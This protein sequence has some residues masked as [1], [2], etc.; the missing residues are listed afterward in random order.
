MIRLDRSYSGSGGIAIIVR[1]NLKYKIIEMESNIN[2]EYLV[3]E[4]SLNNQKKITIVSVYIQPK[5][6]TNYSFIERIGK[7]RPRNTIILGDFNSTH[8]SWGCKKNNPNGKKLKKTLETYNFNIIN[9]LE[10]TFKK[11]QNVIDLAAISTSLLHQTKN[12]KTHTNLGIS[13]HNLISF[14]LTI[15][16]F[17]NSYKITDWVKVNTILNSLHMNYQPVI[18]N[19]MDLENELLKLNTDILE[20]IDK[21]TIVKRLYKG[22]INLPQIIL[23]QINEKKKLQR[24][25]SK[26]H[27]PGIKNKINHLNNKIKRE[28]DNLNK[29][30]WNSVF[31]KI[32]TS[33]PSEKKFWSYI[34]H[35]NNN[36]QNFLPNTDITIKEKTEK[37]ANHFEQIFTNK[38]YN[39]KKS[40][41]KYFNYYKSK[42]YNESI[43]I[44]E[45]IFAIKKVKTSSSSGLDKISN[46]IIKKMPSNTL[47][48]ILKIFNASFDL[49]YVPVNWKI[50]KIILLLKKNQNPDDPN[51]YRGI[52]LLSCIGKLLEIILNK[53]MT[54]WAEKRKILADEQSGF[55]PNRSTQDIIFRLI[56]NVKVLICRRKIK[57]VL[58]CSISKKH[59]IQLHI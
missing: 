22:K 4:L 55:R 39:N 24:L 42:R 8:T 51:S 44:D 30:K 48:F 32:A 7:N 59:S 41:N 31:S 21:A 25:F 46:K 36:Q 52:S 27:D 33:N 13:D 57:L 20:S 29:T 28:I 16:N 45:L 54:H 5:S 47:K 53:R 14:E 19:I 38:T 18:L 50:A 6:K 40:S 11:S 49:G 37:F 3:I 58:Y 34:N 1:N 17:E 2:E 23:T 12:F 15:A 56:E 9:D 43:S 35:E 10:P 26:L